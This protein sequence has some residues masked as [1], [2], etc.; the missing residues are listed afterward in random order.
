MSAAR[1]R[2]RSNDAAIRRAITAA[3]HRWLGRTTIVRRLQ[4]RD[5]SPYAFKRALRSAVEAQQPS[6]ARRTIWLRG[7]V[8][9]VGLDREVVVAHRVQESARRHGFDRGAFRVPSSRGSFP[10]CRLHLYEEFPGVTLERL[11]RRD[12]GEAVRLAH[13]AGRWLARFHALRLRVAPTRTTRDVIREAGFFL[14][15]V[16]RVLPALA[17]RATLVL[18]AAVRSQTTLLARSDRQTTGTHGD[19]NIGNLLRGRDDS[20]ALIDFGSAWID[21]PLSDIGNFLAQ[22][23]LATWRRRTTAANAR[24]L[25]VAFQA[26]YRQASRNLGPRAAERL[27]LYHAWWTLQVLAFSL[28]T[29]PKEARRFASRSIQCAERLLRRRSF[30]PL[31]PLERAAWHQAPAVVTN[32]VLV[33]A[34]FAH[35]LRRFFR[36]AQKIDALTIEHRDA[37]STK[38]FLM[39]YVVSIRFPDGRTSERIIRGNRVDHATYRITERVHRTL[40]GFSSLRPLRYERRLGYEFYE[41]LAGVPVRSLPYDSSRFR[42]RFPTIGRA[43]AAFQATP[44]HGLRQLTWS[45]ELRALTTVAARIRR[46]GG[47][48]ERPFLTTIKIYQARAQPVWQGSPSL[49]HNDFQA[50]NILRTP[51]GVGLIDF[52]QSGVGNGA[53]DAATFIVHLRVML[54]GLVTPPRIEALSRRFLEAYAQALPRPRRTRLRRDLPIFELR[55]LLDVLA[56]TLMNLGPR[57]P[58]RRRY[59]DLVGRALQ[60][61]SE[62]RR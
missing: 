45:N 61:L 25:A 20:V 5:V 57:D 58:N 56:V 1:G 55:S 42:E 51:T 44:R 39:R 11:L 36:G 49:V 3:V 41:E 16:A 2:G 46:F 43:L 10:S 18:D 30:A 33:R 22:L 29:R 54:D 47:P 13:D 15:D 9:S 35:H 8:P 7:N 53:I 40:R 19:L 31:Q 17:G 48:A 34:Y 37:L 32:P 21:D 12:L 23:D 26:S 4:L 38:S 52:T 60:R 14:D 24:R 62:G 27:D 28:S 59:V 50:S 6:G